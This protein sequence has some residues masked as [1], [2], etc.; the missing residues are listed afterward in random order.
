MKKPIVIV[1]AVSACIVFLASVYSYAADHRVPKV[2]VLDSIAQN[3]KAVTFDHATHSM[4]AEKC[5]TCH[6]QHSVGDR[7]SCME[8][9]TLDSSIFKGSVAN[10]FLPC[11]DCH[12]IYD[13]SRPG[14]PGLRGAYHRKCFQ[15]HR[16]MN[17]IGTDPKGCNETCHAKSSIHEVNK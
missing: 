12:G 8:C 15:C 14:M 13:P 5:G 9:H 2:V 7:R 3:Y 10:T 4:I 1:V 11:K 17:G 16:G 6:H